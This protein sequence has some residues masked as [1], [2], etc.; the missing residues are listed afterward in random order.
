MEKQTRPRKRLLL[1]AVERCP[2]HSDEQLEQTTV[3]N[4]ITVRMAST[5]VLGQ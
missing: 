2:M 1:L 3:Q 5:N 4:E